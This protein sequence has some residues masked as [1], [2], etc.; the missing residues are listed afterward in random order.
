MIWGCAACTARPSTRPAPAATAPAY[1]R[2]LARRAIES[3]LGTLS[4]GEWERQWYP[5]YQAVLSW[6]HVQES[7]VE[8]SDGGVMYSSKPS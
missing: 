2:S 7:E 1:A 4:R 8:A 3:L 5:L 6:C